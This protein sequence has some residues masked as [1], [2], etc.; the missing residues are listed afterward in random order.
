MY[1][2]ISDKYD[3]NYQQMQVQKGTDGM[4]FLTS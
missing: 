2:Y 1:S 3:L 4:R